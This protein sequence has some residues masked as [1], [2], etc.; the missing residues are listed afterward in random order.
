MSTSIIDNIRRAGV[1]GAGGAGF[2]THVKYQAR[3][4]LVLANGASCEPLL[5]GDP[6]LLAA[7]TD[8]VL[9]GLSLAMEA[10]DASRGLVCLKPKHRAAWEAVS[11]A[12]PGYKGVG[13]FE[14]AD[15]YPAGDEHVLVNEVTGRVVPQG[16]LPLEVGVVVSNVESLLNVCLAQEG[17]PVVERLITVC[18]E[19]RRPLVA[20]VPIGIS[21]AEVIDL[22]GG[23]TCQDFVVVL[24]GPMMGLAVEDLQTP[25]TK[26]TSGVIVLPSDHYVV[27]A[28]LA[29]PERVRNIARV[30]CCQCNRC[31]DLCPRNLLGHDL[32]PHK[33]MRLLAAQMPVPR[34]AAQK[35]KLSALLCSECGVCE[36]Y[37]CP[38]M[39]S[40]RE[41]NAQ[42]KRE[43]A[44]QGSR[45]EGPERSRPASSFLKIRRLPTARLVERLQVAAYDLHPGFDDRE[46]APERVSIP[47]RQHLGAP[48]E[49]V[50]RPG[51]KVKKGDL[52]G[53]I[54]E[55]ALGA[56]V[57]A[58]LD[59]LVEKVDGSVVIKRK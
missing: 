30:A 3:V 1:V 45:W 16:G 54:P 23:A 17:R 15:F 9:T 28:K 51:Q 22:A 48:A 42:L 8:R 6:H 46:A 59:G 13:V 2:P 31:T 57:H 56:R 43:L 7:E 33:L 39:I 25:V 11:R 29:D 40:P 35:L 14:L 58:S 52:V 4:D 50:V 24:G 41:V 44:A 21:L 38:M 27:R 5:A 37:A 32:E 53:E 19:V 55:G 20:R 47:L 10:V 36:K 34:E 26:T 49:A 12:A 18:G